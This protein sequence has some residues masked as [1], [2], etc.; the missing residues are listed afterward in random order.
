MKNTRESLT[1]VSYFSVFNTS[2][3]CPTTTKKR[4]KVN[5]MEGSLDQ[6]DEM[7]KVVN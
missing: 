4:F 1:T 6:Y 3:K 2:Y 5:E 7:R